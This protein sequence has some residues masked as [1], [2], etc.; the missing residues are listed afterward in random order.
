[1]KLLTDFFVLDTI[2]IVNES[3]TTGTLKVKGVFGRADE[4][5]N[6]NRKYK[7]SILEREVNK[8][9]PL[10]E[11]RR[12]L[13]ELDHP[14][15]TS[16]KLT[17]VS[18][19][20]T[21]LYWEGNKLIGEAEIL[22]TP[23]GKVA[24]QLIKDGVKI[25]ISSRGLGTLVE[26]DTPGKQ[27]VSEDYR[28]VTFD[29]VADPS[30]RGAF[31]GVNESV[32]L[33]IKTKNQALSSNIFL[34]LLE[35]KLNEKY[36]KPVSQNIV[37]N[38]KV[39][40]ILES[41]KQINEGSLGQKRHLRKRKAMV[42]AHSNYMSTTGD[43]SEALKKA[44]KKITTYEVSQEK[45]A[46]KKAFKAKKA[47]GEGSQSIV[48]ALRHKKSAEKK[49]LANAKKFQGSPNYVKDTESTYKNSDKAHQRYMNILRNKIA[50]GKPGFE[51]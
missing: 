18:H 33:T 36:Q 12:L 47:L 30:T 26:S 25:G 19:L 1:M 20:V 39:N 29:L 49:H 48:R 13:G 16:V 14:E 15:Y 32:D 22:N 3:K 37:K 10:M 50:K 24:Q 2:K 46:G 43:R 44:N 34:R 23:S 11:E 6:N 42:K 35:N 7:K 51:E 27:E 4:Y 45:R 17:N 5:N 8:L 21:N 31:P 41:I 9:K 28:M 40:E 38:T